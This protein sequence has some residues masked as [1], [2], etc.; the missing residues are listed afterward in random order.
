MR[1]PAAEGLGTASLTPAPPAEPKLCIAA[2]GPAGA[3]AAAGR[4]TMGASP[5]MLS[6]TMRRS[7]SYPARGIAP[8]K[9][10]QWTLG[11]GRHITGECMPQAQCLLVSAGASP[12]RVGTQQATQCFL[13]LAWGELSTPT[14]SHALQ[15]DARAVQRLG[16]PTLQ[17]ARKGGEQDQK[18]RL[19]R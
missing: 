19:G 15:A 10:V 9:H 13:W 1:C 4:I 5:A 3:G 14:C 11:A 2:G 17:G 18:G 7:G 6:V 8:S 16:H 12:P